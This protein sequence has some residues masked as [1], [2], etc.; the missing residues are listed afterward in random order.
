MYFAFISEDVEGRNIEYLNLSP[1]IKKAKIFFDLGGIVFVILCH[2]G[3]TYRIPY[4]ILESSACETCIKELAVDAFEF[5]SNDKLMN[6]FQKDVYE[7]TIAGQ[8]CT[9]L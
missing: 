4:F 6:F 5:E 3:R 8:K 9:L 7:C 1:F 2:C